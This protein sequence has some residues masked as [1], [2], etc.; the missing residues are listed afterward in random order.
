MSNYSWKNFSS[1][2]KKECYSKQSQTLD[3]T[4]TAKLADFSKADI[5][6][7]QGLNDM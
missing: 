1:I 6:F 4:K 5:W 2:K 3:Y 7:L